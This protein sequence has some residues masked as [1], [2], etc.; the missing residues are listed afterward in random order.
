LE[1]DS[2]QE[3]L[4]LAGLI[5][6][7]A[8]F[9]AAEVAIGSV[10]TRPHLRQELEQDRRGIARV[11]LR[12]AEDSSRLLA[13]VRI[14]V[15]LSGFFAAARVAIVLR[16]QV[17]QWLHSSALGFSQQASHAWA[18]VLV[19]FVLV[20][21]MLLLGELLP[22]SVAD[23]HPRP[24]AFFVAW[25]IQLFSWL[26]FPLVLFLS[27]TS[28]LLVRL[29]G[30]K[31]LKGVPFVSEEEIRTLVDAGEERGAIEW[32]EKEMISGILE[33][34][35]TLV[36]EVMVPRTDIVPLA[37]ETDLLQ[38]LDVIVRAGYSRIPVYRET[39][40]HIMGL[41]YAKDLLPVLRDGKQG[42]PL[43]SLLRPAYFVPETK[44]VDDLLR[45]MQQQRIHQAIVVDEYGGTA[46]LVTIEDLLEEI[47]GEIQDEYDSEEP[48]VQDLGRGEYVFDARLAVDEA[49][50][51]AHLGIPEGDFDTLGGFIYEQLGAI[52]KVGDQVDLGDATITVTSIQGIRP[53]KLHIQRGENQATARPPENVGEQ[54]SLGED[55][56]G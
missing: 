20:C 30:G 38:A 10:A 22:K 45:E 4:L 37:V 41:L 47:V 12:L 46:G 16:P 2:W 42:L 44:F 3:W 34:G 48:L 9:S 52:P 27:G 36:R 31:R 13:T 23:H 55:S 54:P 24:V 51:L 11:L 5:L 21:V 1:T 17:A 39:I 25:P 40:D 28:N 29:F 49:N 8:L 50:K 53:G 7:N 56:D 18:F 6:L 15:V 14:G 32:E 26:F 33:M 43:E 35:K 19:T